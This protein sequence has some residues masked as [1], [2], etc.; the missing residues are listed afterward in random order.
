MQKEVI[1][2][3]LEGRGIKGTMKH[4]LIAIQEGKKFKR[5]LEETQLNSS[6]CTERKLEDKELQGYTWKD[7]LILRF[8]SNDFGEPTPQL[9]LLSGWRPNVMKLAHEHCGHFSHKKTS[10]IIRHSFYWPGLG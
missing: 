9:C 6:L 2:C 5:L 4:Q 8:M 3:S 1:S 10:E 7:G